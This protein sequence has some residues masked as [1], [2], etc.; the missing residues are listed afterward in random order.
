MA[1]AMQ[2][3]STQQVL[4]ALSRGDRIAV[5]AY[6]LGGSV[7]HAIE[8]AASR[9]AR[10]VVR[11]EGKPYED[12]A[13]RL[14][15]RNAAVVAE[16]RAAGADAGFEHLL[17]A[18]EISVDGA[19]Y[20]DEKNWRSGDL[21]LR[22]DDPAERAA[23]PAI[24]HEALARE[25]AL[26]LDSRKTG[27]AIV[28]SESFGRYNAVYSALRRL[29]CEGAAPRLLVCERDVHGNDRE[30]KALEELVGDGVRVRICRDSEKLALAGG[31]AWLGSANATAAFKSSDTIDW[32]ISTGDP[33]IVGAVRDRVEAAWAGARDFKGSC[34]T[35]R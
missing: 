27:S 30:R 6:T 7:L 3:S 8:D 20:L 32:G 12:P 28:E 34:A 19:L 2:L 22:V 11:L 16:L 21:V 5:E 17:H 24:K 10:V 35:G 33:T 1:G 31:R 29:G 14:A 9:G 25:A 23:I 26:L 4:T 13:G 18:K 15:E